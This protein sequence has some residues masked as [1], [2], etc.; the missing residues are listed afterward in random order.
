V[1]V[2]DLVRPAH[3]PGIPVIGFSEHFES[4]VDKDV[5]H[6]E[7]G[8]AVGKDT[9]ADGKSL[10]ERSGGPQIEKGHAHHGIE[11]KKG[12][13][14]FE[15]GVV[16]LAVV[17]PVKDPKKSVHDILMCKPRHEL[18]DAEGH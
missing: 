18:H 15:P 4:L 11:N 2:V 1:F 16:I 5:M 7:I 14:S 8:N 6:Q 9:K 17:I 3:S 12:V 10:P 13:I